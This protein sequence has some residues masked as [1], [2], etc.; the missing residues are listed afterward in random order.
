MGIPLGIG[1][2]GFPIPIGK[3]QNS[4]WEKIREKY[5]VLQ[6]NHNKK[7]MNEGRNFGFFL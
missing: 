4:Q 2:F 7:P 6:A 5:R 3:F 1:N